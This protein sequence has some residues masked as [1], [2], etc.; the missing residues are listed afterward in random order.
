MNRWRCLHDLTAAQ[1]RCGDLKELRLL[2]AE[3]RAKRAE[4]ADALHK[5]AELNPKDADA[6]LNAGELYAKAGSHDE[7]IADSDQSGRAGRRPEAGRASANTMPISRWARCYAAQRRAPIR[8]SK[9][10]TRPLRF[11]RRT[12]VPL[13]NKGVLQEQAGLKADAEAS[14]RSALQNDPG[15]VADSNRAGHAAGRRGQCG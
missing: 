7:A 9:I 11:S 4:A 5:A 6:W 15:N 14:Y 10:S 13:Y 12:R 2:S 1:S 8:P 3:S